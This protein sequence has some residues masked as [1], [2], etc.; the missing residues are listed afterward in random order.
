MATSLDETRKQRETSP[1]TVCLAEKTSSKAYELL[2]P[3]EA[4]HIVWMGGPGSRTGAVYYG[5]DPSW[6]HELLSGVI[7]G[8]VFLQLQSTPGGR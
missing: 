2:C 7:A 1:P 6:Q 5:C 8:D 3:K 4:R